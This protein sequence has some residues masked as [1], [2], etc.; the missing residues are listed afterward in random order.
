MSIRYS[1]I[2]LCVGLAALSF[3]A[4]AALII[5]DWLTPG[6][7]LITLDTVTQLEWLDFDYVSYDF[8]HQEVR[9]DDVLDRLSDHNDILYGWR[10]ATGEEAVRLWANWGVDLSG[11]ERWEVYELDDGF[12]QA[13]QF[14]G[15]SGGYYTIDGYKW[16]TMGMVADE[17]GSAQEALGARY[18]ID[19]QEE[20]VEWTTYYPLGSAVG[21]SSEPIGIYLVRSVPEPATVWLLITAIP[22][23][24]FFYRKKA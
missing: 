20:R 24:V 15:D 14:I 10:V 8:P 4:R 6:D 21:E 13:N 5:V 18:V 19:T 17:R 12:L 7:D 22:M 11:G 23:L 1:V 9:Y 3:N 16:F 2:A